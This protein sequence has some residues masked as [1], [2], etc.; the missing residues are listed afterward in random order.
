[1][2]PLFSL[3]PLA[4]AGSAFWL[5]CAAPSQSAPTSAP[6]A[7]TSTQIVAPPVAPTVAFAPRVDF[8]Q[9][10]PALI[11]VS[12]VAVVRAQPGLLW[13]H[14]DSGDT[15]RIFAVNSVGKIA[16]TVNL[17]GARALDWEDCDAQGDW[18]YAGDIGDNL[19]VRPDIQI[20][21]F[22][23][24]RINPNKV[25]VE[26]NLNP[27][28]WQVMTLLWPDG[29]HNCESLAVTPDGRLLLVSKE[30]S[31]LSGFYV[32]D[33]PFKDKSAATLRK[34]GSFQF[35]LTGMFTKLATGADFSPDGRK[36]VVTTY[37]DLY[38]FP[39]GRAFD[40]SSLRLVPSKEPLPPQ[41]QCEAVCYSLDGKTIYSTGEGK[42]QPVWEVAS[43]LK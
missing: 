28:G 27:K 11:E 33:K 19:K 9:D 24:P 13:M 34:I 43:R 12:G 14:N 25:G 6:P 3:A 16:M 31:G 32:V 17:Q 42:H 40:F 38:E 21:R 20:Y 29:A 5:G 37:S 36:L 30:E 15:A 2:K 41:R 26:L 22:R 39:L 7:P 8:K 18:V 4:L 35:G 10:D 23:Q 1:M